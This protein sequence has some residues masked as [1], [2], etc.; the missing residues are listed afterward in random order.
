M[1]NG[2][3][4]KHAEACQAVAETEAPSAH[5]GHEPGDGDENR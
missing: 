5:S 4:D 2:G 3:I 1:P